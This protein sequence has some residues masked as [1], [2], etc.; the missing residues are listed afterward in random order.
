MFPDSLLD[1]FIEILQIKQE[2]VNR[3]NILITVQRYSSQLLWKGPI[4]PNP[5]THLGLCISAC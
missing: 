3:K 4:L 5:L 1:H 2:T